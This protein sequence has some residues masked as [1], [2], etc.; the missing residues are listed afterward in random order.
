MLYVPPSQRKMKRASSRSPEQAQKKS[1]VRSTSSERHQPIASTSREPYG[2][3]NSPRRLP[4]VSRST[5]AVHLSPPG[6]TQ[7][8]PPPPRTLSLPQLATS[9]PSPAFAPPPSTQINPSSSQG[10]TSL[11]PRPTSKKSKLTAQQK[12]EIARGEPRPPLPT[13]T[14]GQPR[15]SERWNIWFRLPN[16]TKGPK[17]DAKFSHGFKGQVKQHHQIFASPGTVGKTFE[18][19]LKSVLEDVSRITGWGVG[20]I[21]LR[22]EKEIDD[23]T[24]EVLS[25][26]GRETVKAEETTLASWGVPLGGMIDVFEV[27]SE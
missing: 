12:W 18:R 8:H 2:G 11:L 17:L 22:F 23:G 26:G 13:R 20:D 9:A 24:T 19:S 21:E 4:S 7:Y 16:E 5:S 6:T 15:K 10:Q 1:R 25:C 3:P 27:E 14:A